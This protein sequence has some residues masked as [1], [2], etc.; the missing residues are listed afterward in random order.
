[1]IKASKHPN[2]N[3]IC[4]NEQFHGYYIEERPNIRFTSGTTFVNSFFPKFDTK[5]VS[6]RYAAKHRLDAK[7][8]RKEWKE[9]SRKS[10]LRGVKYHAYAEDVY[11]NVDNKF[12]NKITKIIDKKF[13]TLYRD[14][15]IPVACE[16]IIASPELKVA[17]M[18]DLIM[19]K[20]DTLLISDWKFV[21]EITRQNIW[22][23]AKF[24]IQWLPDCNYFRYVLQLNLYKYLIK[25][26][27]YYPNF[28]NYK[29]EIYHV[30]EGGLEV[31]DV[32]NYINTIKNMMACGEKK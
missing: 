2:G 13:K 16:K 20:G 25:R 31:I 5:L 28:K 26:E 1:M 29:L 27:G 8:V 10:R 14:G 30:T 12:S 7:Q 11:N 4:F 17:G 32:P 9:K 18:V 23:N 21:G 19:G 24:P 22:Q 15:Y 3:I 6:E